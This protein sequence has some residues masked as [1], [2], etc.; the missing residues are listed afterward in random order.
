MK[1]QY[2]GD[3][4]DLFKYDLLL[5]LIQ[6]HGA[7][8]LTFVPMLTPPDE[9]G[10]G[11]LTQADSRNRRAAVY[12]FLQACVASG[13]RDIRRLREMMPTFGVRFMPFRDDSWF[14]PKD[15]ADYFEA[16]PNEHLTNSVVFFDPDIGL[17]T[18]STSYMRKKGL[19]KYLMYSDLAGVWARLSPGS[20][21]VVYQHLQKD[22]TKRARDVER[23][24]RG[25]SAHLNASAWAIQWNDLAFWRQQRTIMWAARSGQR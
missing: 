12:D 15:R 9:S 13:Q 19:E 22:A 16:V 2:F 1:N 18:G 11:R 7:W 23:R 6:V 10:E 21:V 25:L 14:V 8:R 5:D 3:R 17:E 4:R 24:V 20:V